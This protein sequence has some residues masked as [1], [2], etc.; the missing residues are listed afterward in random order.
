M[1]KVLLIGDTH[2]GANG[3]SPRL[4]RQNVELYKNFIF[5]IIKE[6]KIDFCIDLGDFFDDREKIDIKTLKAVREEMLN[7]LPCPF[8]FIV[9]N[10]NQYY[11]NNNLLNNLEATIGD[12]EGVNI[13]DHFMQVDRIDIYPWIMD[14]NVETYKKAIDLTENPFACGHFE[15]TGF[16]FDKSRVADVKEKLP[17][18]AFKKYKAVFSGH[19]HVASQKD[20]VIYVGSPIQLTWIDCDVEKRVIVLD[21]N[22]GEWFD[23]VNPN[24]LYAQFKIDESGELVGVK[25]EDIE[26]KRIKIHYPVELEKEKVNNLQAILKS[27]NPDQL[28]FVP[29]GQKTKVSQTVSI[30]EGLEKALTDYVRAIPNDNEKIKSVIEKLVLSYYNKSH[31]K[32]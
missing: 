2:N 15:F 3:N 26:D 22:T 23:I 18:S 5:P 19:Y 6:H 20:N 10:H 27:W 31:N 28:S 16:Q 7:D 13:V 11:K 8:Y 29:Y 21:T 1:A 4:L 12:I 25:K 24:T 9:G 32:E 14:K 17:A 30:T